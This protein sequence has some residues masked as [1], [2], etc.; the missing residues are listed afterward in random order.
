MVEVVAQG[1][2]TA[3]PAASAI[4]RARVAPRDLLQA[5]AGR[6]AGLCYSPV[7]VADCM[8]RRPFSDPEPLSMEVRM[9]LTPPNQ[10]EPALA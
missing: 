10:S 4:P 6:V 3:A 7:V 2:K 5:V 9:T 1:V 8:R